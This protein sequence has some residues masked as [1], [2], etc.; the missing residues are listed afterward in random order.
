VS[1]F[2]FHF[3]FN[4]H[5]KKEERKTIYFDFLIFKALKYVFFLNL[6]YANGILALFEFIFNFDEIKI[7]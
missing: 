1:F 6:N 5:S 2:H 3:I 7:I 4:S